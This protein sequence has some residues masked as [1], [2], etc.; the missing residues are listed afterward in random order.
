MECFNFINFFS[1]SIDFLY[2]T[3]GVNKNEEGIKFNLFRENNLIINRTIFSIDFFSFL[4]SKL[5]LIDQRIKILFHQ[6]GNHPY[7]ILLNLNSFYVFNLQFKK[8]LRKPS[9]SVIGI[10]L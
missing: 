7:Q 1:N 6:Q 5:L 4:V 3:Y 9:S 8:I 10:S 2:S